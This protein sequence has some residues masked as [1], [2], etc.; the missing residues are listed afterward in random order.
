MRCNG[1]PNAHAPGDLR[2]YL[3]IWLEC[4]AKFNRN[5]LNWILQISEQSTLTQDSNVINKTCE[6]LKSQQTNLGDTYSTKIKEV[7]GVSF[8]EAFLDA[9]N[10]IVNLF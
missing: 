10:S 1:Q 9:L 5:E 8:F 2:K 4:M 6:Y 7:L 3:H